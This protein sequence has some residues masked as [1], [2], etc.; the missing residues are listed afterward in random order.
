MWEVSTK[1]PVRADSLP[2]SPELSSSVSILHRFSLQGPPV[3]M[4]PKHATLELS[5]TTPN[6]PRR[7]T[8]ESLPLVLVRV[9][10]PLGVYVHVELDVLE[11]VRNQV[12]GPQL[13]STRV[14]PLWLFRSLLIL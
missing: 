12:L 11:R 5:A 7:K 13:N 14:V 2:H 9:R 1:T 8:G 4:F 6:R 10:V 3:Q